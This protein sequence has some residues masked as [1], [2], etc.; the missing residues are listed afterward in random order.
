MDKYVFKSYNAIFPKLFEAE[1]SR[2]RKHL[3]GNFEIEHVGSTAVPG[4]GG[5][6][7]IDL[8]VVTEINNLEHIE[9]EIIKSGYEFRIL[10]GEDDHKFF[11]I[12]LPDKMEGIRR[13]H[14][15][16]GP[17]DSKDFKKLVIFRDYLKTHP[18]DLEK[19]AKA[20]QKAA[21]ESEQIRDKYISIK[22]PII[23]EILRKATG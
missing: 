11:R 2:L 4:L 23:E 9:K 19:Y 15:H 13:Y 14:L 6:G 3:T 5:K 7:I 18:K 1:K 21:K 12:D 8:Y 10:I 20:K 22:A 17:I 16:L